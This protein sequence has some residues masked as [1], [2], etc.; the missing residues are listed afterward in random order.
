MHRQFIESCPVIKSYVYLCR[1]LY[2]LWAD[3]V[4]RRCLLRVDFDCKY[5][6]RGMLMLFVVINL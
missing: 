2:S 1:L 4:L 5:G 3:W 6:G